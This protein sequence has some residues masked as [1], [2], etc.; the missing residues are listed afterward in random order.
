M[1][2][3]YEVKR[4]VC[5]A[6]AAAFLNRLVFALAIPRVIETDAIHYLNMGRQ[7]LGGDFLN[8]DENLPVLYSLLGAL[9]GTL[10]ADLETA[11]RIV[12]F[13]ASTLLV[14]PVYS[15]ARRMFDGGAARIAVTLV[16][17]WPWL[18]DYG[19]RVGPE[20]LA[21]TLWFSAIALLARALRDGG[22]AVVIAPVAFFALHLARP[23]GTFHMLAAPVAGLIL[24][25]GRER[26]EVPGPL[27]RWLISTALI[28]SLLATYAVAMR[29][30]IGTAT[31]SYR[32][33]MAGDLLT[34][35]GNGGLELFRTFRT[36]SFEALPVMLGPLF[37]IFLG[38]GMFRPS[39]HARDGRIE[40]ALL[41]FCGIQFGLTIANFSPAPRY[42]MPV[43]IALSLWSARGLYLVGQQ[44]SAWLGS[45]HSQPLRRRLE[46]LPQ[47]PLGA[48][49]ALLLL[50]GLTAI[51]G[52]YAGSIPREPVEYKVAGKWMRKHLEPGYVITRKPQVGFYAGMPTTGPA[53]EDG[54]ADII[55]RAR[56]VGARY[57]V[58]DER[59]TARMA[60]RLAP[61]LNPENAP[62]S[63]RLVA[64]KL[65]PYENGRVVIYEIVHPDVEYRQPEDFPKVDSF[66]GPYQQRRMRHYPQSDP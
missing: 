17:L 53:P 8:F 20:A 44:A 1:S 10:V 39:E 64:D 56:L 15:L 54:P 31:V 4:D 9:V 35:F 16:V 61:L 27:R 24:F 58:L 2:A 36:A 18:A 50:G 49:V 43:V 34:Y 7:F 63:L 25:A 6:L 37:L 13:V 19:F 59:H 30:I 51:A 66:M 11:F 21:V 22:W 12:S 52:E 29:F 48:A 33:P 42:L 41:L 26:S 3:S 47:A 23:E 40:V 65:S 45:L 46:W 32:A 14:V 57:F 28:V 55:R 60:P 5:V 62:S 38:V